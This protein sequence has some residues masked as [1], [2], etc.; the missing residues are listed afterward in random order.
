MIPER[1]I[2]RAIEAGITALKANPALIDQILGLDDDD[3]IAKARETFV[4]QAPGVV[5]GFPRKSTPMPCYAIALLNDQQVRDFVGI[6]EEAYIDDD[7]EHDGSTYTQRIRESYGIYTYSNHPD[8]T[9]WFYRIV[10]AILNI[11]RIRFI[12]NHFDDPMLSGADL[13]PSPEYR[14][15]DLFVRRL[16]IS[17]DYSETWNDRD[18]L[19][20]AING[21]PEEYL[22]TGGSTNIRHEDSGGE[23]HPISDEDIDG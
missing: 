2:K 20:Q 10:R 7:D 12:N 8:V 11:A 22:P 1:H 18:A 21:T 15:E 6:G 23:V 14:G 13:A 3:E 5:L 19:W 17:L 4:A 16:T 9:V